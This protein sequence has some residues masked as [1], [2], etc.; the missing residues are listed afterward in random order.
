LIGDRMATTTGWRILH[1]HDHAPVAEED[2]LTLTG[3]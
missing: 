2:S 3:G 1:L